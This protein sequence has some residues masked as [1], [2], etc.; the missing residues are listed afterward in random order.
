MSD[1]SEAK[2]IVRATG[3]YKVEGGIPLFD[4]EG[5]PIDTPPDGRPYSLCRCGHSRTKPFCD[6]SHKTCEW[7]SSLNPPDRSTAPSDSSKPRS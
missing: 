3:S 6:A 1:V 4:S 7:D 2:I 5:N